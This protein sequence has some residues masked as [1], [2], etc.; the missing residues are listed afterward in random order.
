M[1]TETNA[2]A[3]VYARS[4]IEL[5]EEAG[6]ADKI[7]EVADELEGLC[8]L[9]RGDRAFA[10]FLSSPI[11][12]ANRREESLRRIFS[13]RITD[14]TL[15]FLLVLNQKGRIGQL[16]EIADAYDLIVQE[17]YGKVEVDLFTA[18]QVPAEQLEPLRDR[19]RDAIG[20]EPVIYPYVDGSMIGG[21]KL[22]IG[23]QLIDGS[24]ATKLRRLAHGLGERRR[25]GSTSTMFEEEG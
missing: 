15:R 2:L 7:A 12:G 10:E 25:L 9:V 3:S 16:A 1:A 21:V 6:G 14:L 13:D 11:V 20:R 8:G 22:R 24:V 17:R 5:A 4:L 18:R 19:I 23:D